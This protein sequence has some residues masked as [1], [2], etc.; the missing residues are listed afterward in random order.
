MRKVRAKKVRRVEVHCRRPVP[1][2]NIE[3]EFVLVRGNGVA[4]CGQM[5]G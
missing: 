3:P 2:P 5:E 1:T 4:V